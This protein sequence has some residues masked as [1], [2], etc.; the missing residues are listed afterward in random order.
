MYAACGCRSRAS[1]LEPY[2]IKG[3]TDF[4]RCKRCGVVLRHPMPTL[5]ELDRIYADLYRSSNIVDGTT[6]QSSSE[7]V[8]RRYSR[9]LMRGIVRPGDSVLDFGCGTGHLV[10]CLQDEGIDAF[11]IERSNAARDFA[12]LRHGLDLCATPEDVVDGSADVVTMIE[13]V[14]HLPNPLAELET[15]RKKIRRGGR[16]FVTTPNRKGL[17]ARLEGGNW[18]EAQKKF[19]VVLF[20]P[21]SLR[22]LLLSAGFRRVRRIRFSP[23]QRAGFVCQVAARALQVAGLAG[24]VCLTAEVGK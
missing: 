21:S 22:A 17:R 19:H 7:R 15:I 20:D 14:E 2:F 3:E 18:R 11:G 5:A 13:V 12:R 6:N 23:V 1:V 8:L 16:I 24:T 4:F 9:F 10:R